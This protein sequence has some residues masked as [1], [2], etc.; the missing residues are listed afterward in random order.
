[1][2]SRPGLRGRVRLRNAVAGLILAATLTT[3]T[4]AAASS[5]GHHSAT[6]YAQ[7]TSYLGQR[8]G[9]VSVAVY[10]EVAHTL[11]VVHPRVRGWTASIVK[12][13]ILETL[14]HKQKGRLSA[15]QRSLATAMIERSDNDAASDL[16]SADGGA[17]GVRRYDKLVGL[18][19]TTPAGH[20][21][22]GLTTTSAAD[23]VTLIRELVGG[24]SALGARSRQ[25]T[26][27]LMTHVTAAQRWGV[28]AGPTSRATVGLKNGWLPVTQDH[29][30]WAVNSIGWVSAPHRRYV[31]AVITQHESSEQ[32]GIST[33]EHISRLVWAGAATD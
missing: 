27:R 20:G 26:R 33:I 9:T 2:V 7:I 8:H 25:L 12:V 11:L 5:G 6:L 17:A 4:P 15:S 32:Y 10:D 31:I 16:W 19:Q 14:L 30:R 1:V 22:W 24:H 23:Q 29:N 18:T 3:G 21:L 13:D 28:S